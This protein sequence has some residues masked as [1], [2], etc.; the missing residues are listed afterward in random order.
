MIKRI[1]NGVLEKYVREN[2]VWNKGKKCPQFSGKNNP[3]FK[4][5]MAGTK[6]YICWKHIR[7]RCFN[8]NSKDFVNYGGRGIK[9]LWESFEEFRNDMY[10]SYQSHI[11]EFGEKN[12]TIERIDN[13]GHYCKENCR[14]ANRLIQTRNRRNN[15]FYSY[16]GKQMLLI[17]LTKI[18]KIKPLTIRRRIFIKGWSIHKAITKPLMVNQFR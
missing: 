13:N 7:D 18:S 4:H 3:T 10:E 15:K 6:F 16:K 12:T 5:G 17:D 11:K 8:K 14:W 2:G 1:S 9:C